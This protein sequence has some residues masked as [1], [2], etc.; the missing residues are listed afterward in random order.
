MK[1]IFTGYK[2]IFVCFLFTLAIE[3]GYSQEKSLG[4]DNNNSQIQTIST[5]N[6]EIETLNKPLKLI[7]NLLTELI[8]HINGHW[9]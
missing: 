7:K 3:M 9:E 4:N 2:K 1:K 5:N 6:N 8:R